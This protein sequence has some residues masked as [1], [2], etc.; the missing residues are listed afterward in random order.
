MGNGLFSLQEGIRAH[1]QKTHVI[2]TSVG[3]L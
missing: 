3:R 1:L 2:T